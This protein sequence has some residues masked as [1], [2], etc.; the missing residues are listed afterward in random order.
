MNNNEKLRN[1]IMDLRDMRVRLQRKVAELEDK[2]FWEPDTF[3]PDDEYWL[4]YYKADTA[5]I[6]AQEQ[7]LRNQMC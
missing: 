1:E 5:R 4:H 3:S 6:K 2:K 7:A